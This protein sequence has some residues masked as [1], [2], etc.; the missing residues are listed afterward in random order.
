MT[1][2]LDAARPFW[3]PVAHSDDV[4]PGAALATKLLDEELVIWRDKDGGLAVA[5][6]VCPHRGTQLSMG[7]VTDEGCLRCPYHLF[8]F[9]SDGACT[10]IPQL[11][12]KPISQRVRLD[13]YGAMEAADLIWV[14]LAPAED[15]VHPAPVVPRA[16]DEDWW[17]YAGPP[18]VWRC[19]A[20]RMLE[21]FLDL[22]HFGA[23]HSGSFGNP[24]VH[25][26][27]AYTPQVLEEEN[28]ITFEVD[29]LA[30]YRWAPPVDGQPAVRP[31]HY[32]Y[33]C[34][35]PFSAWI[36]TNVDGEL[37]YYTF[38]ACQ[39]VSIDVTRIF[40]VTTFPNE[41]SHTPAELDDGFIPFFVEDQVI[42]E[43]QRPEW[44]PLDIGDELQMPFDKI[45]VA[46][47]RSL[48]NLGFPTVRLL[49]S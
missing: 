11:P 6:D 16:D 28:A 29:Y 27:A 26:V 38:I 1:T 22:A 25:E 10:H 15:R 5:D 35:L 21:N 18:Q 8:E 20:P 32:R 2:F 44:L 23:I 31:I 24:E 45:S 34:D 33:R 42:V 49:R 19:Q 12:D 3:H 13:T 46:Y 47:R 39:P 43:K 30:R 7:T 9:S 41:V 17:L 37:P 36:E 48:Q 40:W 4:Q 14:C